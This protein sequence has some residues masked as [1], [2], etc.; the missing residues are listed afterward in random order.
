MEG[1]RD[2]GIPYSQPEAG[3]VATIV[4]EAW[5]G[6]R[7]AYKVLTAPDKKGLRFNQKRTSNRLR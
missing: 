5:R 2:A 7:G 1:R 3:K 6:R 4:S